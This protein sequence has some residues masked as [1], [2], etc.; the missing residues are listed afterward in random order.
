MTVEV[1]G[2]GGANRNFIRWMFLRWEMARPD[3]S[4]AEGDGY[5]AVD[6]ICEQ[7]QTVLDHK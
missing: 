2:D 6:Q 5:G 4:R 3:I 7:M 1:D